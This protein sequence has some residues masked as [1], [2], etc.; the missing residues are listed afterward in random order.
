M[1]R[2]Y[3]ILLNALQKNFFQTI[4]M[5]AS[6]NSYRHQV[7]KKTSN[8]TLY[9]LPSL[10]VRWQYVTVAD[11]LYCIVNEGLQGCNVGTYLRVQCCEAG[12]SR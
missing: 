6:F 12:A 8:Y 4:D 7:L 9:L 5:S 10:F 11:L 3:V 2:V 1:D